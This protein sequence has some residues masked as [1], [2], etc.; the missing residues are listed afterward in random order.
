M[1][2]APQEAYLINKIREQYRFGEII[3]ECRNGL[4]NRIGKTTIY[5]YIPKESIDS[6]G[7]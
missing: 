5:E 3:I 2:L 4:P 6:S 1:E 7:I